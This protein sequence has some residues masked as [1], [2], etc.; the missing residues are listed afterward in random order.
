MSYHDFAGD[1]EKVYHA[2]VLGMLIWLSNDY[3]IR[4]NRE[5][6]YGR[7][8]IIF[9]PKDHSRQGIIIEFKRIDEDDLVEDVLDDALKQIEKKRYDVELKAA[10]IHNILKLAVGFTSKAVYLKKNA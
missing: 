2:L 4:S 10:N 5:S 9:I 6:G 1:P 7:Y 8:D 3:T